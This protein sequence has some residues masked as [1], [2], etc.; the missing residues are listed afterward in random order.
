MFEMTQN[1]DNDPSGSR[2]GGTGSSG[3]GSHPSRHEPSGDPKKSIL[4][5]IRSLLGSSKGSTHLRDDLAEYVANTQDDST[6]SVANHERTLISNVLDLRDMRAV[7]VMIPRVDI[8]AIDISISESELF[9]LLSEKQFS[10]FPVFR[11]S[12][13]DVI[14][15][16]HIKDILSTTLRKEPIVLENLVRDVP[17]VSP[18]MHVLDL[19]LEMKQTRRH[20]ALVVDEFGGIDGL[21]TIGDI[22]EAIVGDV[23]DEHNTMGSDP[24]LITN[25]D[26]SIIADGRF[27]VEEFED[28]FGEFMTEE[29]RES[30]DTLG[31]LVFAI[32]GRV[33]SR[34]EILVHEESGMIFEILDADAR[35]VKRLRVKNVKPKTPTQ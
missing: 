22:I 27:D 21:V 30:I 1:D 15:T 35:R 18:S 33:P 16:V 14:G 9:A 13:D 17:I 6:L 5:Q 12:L 26:G 25:Q 32:A 20:M 34:G 24:T 7:D 31:G 29:E 3:Y 2:P 23:E 28:R 8:V 19:L 4:T 11:E 10:R